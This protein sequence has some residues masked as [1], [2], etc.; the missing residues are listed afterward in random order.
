MGHDEFNFTTSPQPN[1][2]ESRSNPII[3]ESAEIS[4]E[5]TIGERT[6]I[7][8]QSQIREGVRI[9]KD[10]SIGKN[11]YIDKGVRIGDRVKIQNGVS[12]FQG[13]TI[14]DQVFIGPYATFTND[15]FPRAMYENFKREE[16]LLK[17]GSSVGANATI[18]CGVTL[19]EYSMLGA[20]STLTS[21]T[22]PYGLYVGSPARLKTFITPCGKKLELSEILDGTVTFVSDEHELTI[23]FKLEAIPKKLS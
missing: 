5:A 15:R 17:K 4:D 12:I 19:S 10:C 16:T 21:S 20:G 7:W 13:V 9:G 1:E 3:H 6:R 2:I 14:E 23:S 18:I 11:V 22:L 8:H